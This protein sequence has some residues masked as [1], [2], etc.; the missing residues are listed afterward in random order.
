MSTGLPPA[1]HAAAQSLRYCTVCL[2]DLRLLLTPEAVAFWED[3][4]RN[5]PT[6]LQPQFRVY[7]RRLE[8]PI[9]A[10]VMGSRTAMDAR[11]A[12]L[13]AR[14]LASVTCVH[15]ARLMSSAT[16]ISLAMSCSHAGHRD[17]PR[18]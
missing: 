12:A 17:S 18:L 11:P 10:S 14:T 15:A 6:S 3:R 9:R 7:S 1:L 13:L 2:P 16:L 5:R 8:R 4:V